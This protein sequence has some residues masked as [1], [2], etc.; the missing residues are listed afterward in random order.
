MA[1]STPGQSQGNSESIAGQPP[2]LD[3]ATHGGDR[4]CKSEPVDAAVLSW[5][6]VDSI[7]L[8][9]HAVDGIV[10]AA[11]YGWKWGNDNGGILGWLLPLVLAGLGA[12]WQWMRAKR[13]PPPADPEPVQQ[14]PAPPAPLPAPMPA[15]PDPVK[16][17]LLQKRAAIA[18]HAL[19]VTRRWVGELRR[20]A[21]GD[22]CGG[23]TDPME[24]YHERWA[25]IFALTDE[26]TDMHNATKDLSM[27]VW[28]AIETIWLYKGRLQACQLTYVKSPDM[29]RH[30]FPEHAGEVLTAILRWTEELLTPYANMEEPRVT[31]AA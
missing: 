10:G 20:V 25:N 22:S 2:G 11:E 8:V 16:L 4:G 13:R 29:F 18:D 31:S 5:A 19:K 12:L 15:Q 17:L 3:G 28:W 9:Q 30:A 26:F 24:R 7:T 23:S 1:R 27:E 21:R 6:P 14:L